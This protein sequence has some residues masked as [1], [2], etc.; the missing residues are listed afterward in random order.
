M[1]KVI[2]EN[3]RESELNTVL[4][5]RRCERYALLERLKL[6]LQNDKRIAAAWSI[7]SN[8]EEDDL[9]GIDL[10]VVVY[11]EYINEFCNI[12]YE[13]VSQIGEM[14]LQQ[15]MR[16]DRYVCLAVL[17]E[18]Y[19]GPQQANY[20]W[21]SLSNAYVPANAKV[22]LNRE[23]ITRAGESL[24]APYVMNADKPLDTIVEKVNHFW[25]AQMADAVYVARCPNSTESNLYE[26]QTNLL[27]DIVTFL[28]DGHGT[29][30]NLYHNNPVQKL[31]IL[32]NFHRVMMP[33][34]ADI[35]GQ[36]GDMPW[37]IIPAS[38]RFITL[39]ETVVTARN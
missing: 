23:N 36:G 39:M 5:A 33:L 22:V 31:R 19:Y 8:K 12:Q 10:Q 11:D 6:L 16:T 13:Y 28:G 17:Y 9:S 3:F 7:D 4:T 14:I 27:N 20:T 15:E 24:Q 21:I 29:S 26:T 30:V 37:G 1:A 38:I 35:E 32:R 2:A 18:G 25:L 34:M